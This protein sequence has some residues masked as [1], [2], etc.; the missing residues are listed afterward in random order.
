M[1]MNF[2]GSTDVRRV[3]LGNRSLVGRNRLVFLR[4]AQIDRERREAL[5][6]QEDSANTIQRACQRYL[7]L[8]SWRYELSE[9][10]DGLSIL[11]FKYFFPYLVTKQSREL[12]ISQLKEIDRLF[13]SLNI[14]DCSL[15]LD[16]F[17]RSVINLAEKYNSTSD[18][19]LKSILPIMVRI[20]QT[21]DTIP[22]KHSLQFTTSL[23]ELY[24]QN[25][26]NALYYLCQLM[27][28]VSLKHLAL[29]IIKYTMIFDISISKKWTDGYARFEAKFL[30]K[31][32][33]QPDVLISL[34]DDRKILLVIRIS[35]LTRQ[36]PYFHPL[37]KMHFSIV[38]IL[39][40]SIKCKIH[41]V[42]EKDM[43]S[44]GSISVYYNNEI[45]TLTKQ[46]LNLFEF[47]SNRIFFQGV[48]NKEPDVDF[49]IGYISSLLQFATL[50]EGQPG[51]SLKLN[52][53][54]DW[55]IKDHFGD[56]IPT[57]IQKISE[58]TDIIYLESIP[59][60]TTERFLDVELH[61]AW[62]RPMSILQEFLLDILSIA[63]DENLFAA[64]KM[65]KNQVIHFGTFLKLMITEVLMKYRELR[66][67]KSAIDAQGLFLAYFERMLSLTH[68]LYMKDLRLKIFMDGFWVLHNFEF[69]SEAI[70]N[71]IP[72]INKL[73][74]QEIPEKEDK[75]VYNFLQ[76]SKL[77]SLTSSNVPK[78]IIDSLY[79][80]TYAPYVIPFEKRA[81]IFHG[82]IYHDK[83]DRLLL[84]W[85]PRKVEATVSR[86]NILFD[87][88]IEFGSVPG[89]EFKRPFSISF[90]NKFGE[91]EAGIDGGG[92][93][94]EFLT[95]LVS[96]SFIPSRENRISN[97]GLQFFREGANHKLYFN[98]EYYFKLEYEKLH[99][100]QIIPFDCE[101]G[102]YHDFCTLLG[103]VIGKCLYDN[104]L[105]DISFTPFF[106]NACATMGGRY[107]SN[108]IGD[109][110]EFIG[111]SFSFDELKNLDSSL[112]H[113]LNYILKQTTE[114]R[115]KEMAIDCVVD[116]DVYDVYGRKHH[117]TLPLLPPGPDGKPVPVTLE[118]RYKFVRLMTSFKLSKQTNLMMKPFVE[119]LFQV[120]S[121]HWFVLFDPYE[122][123][124]LI[125]GEDLVDLEDLKNNA[126]LGGGYTL[127][128]PTIIDLFEILEEFNHKERGEFVKF[129]TSSSK[130]PLLGFKELEPKFGIFRAGPTGNRLPTASTCINLLKLPDY[131]NKEI[132]RDKLLYSIKSGAGF[133]LS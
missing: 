64:I 116:D 67:R 86:D 128:S 112:Y 68:G 59:T 75:L 99:P 98:P 102:D 39:L 29:F 16:A 120:I 48:Y 127:Q 57:C 113:S 125:S 20:C 87:S 124:T 14:H 126:V 54:R 8:Q 130:Q 58:F 91:I 115:F 38:Q 78:K 23:I 94:K 106:L 1:S 3:N 101:D 11:H 63:A 95:S 80:L 90:V 32:L 55:L 71:I 104:I 21:Y 33:A 84:E 49:L 25:F 85:N 30:E 37:G 96:S 7:K 83:K 121:P 118:N 24:E 9:S 76:N 110:V 119:G 100:N 31:L 103:R 61:R 65:T 18:E 133:D 44:R 77:T 50:I 74:N 34:P 122:L 56:L 131:C 123:Q 10:W 36:Y 45:L 72:L 13:D 6:L 97:H 47:L 22:S 93:T 69:D 27:N 52:I 62:W 70:I 108:L 41:L 12:S 107:F 117:V 51:V 73:H 82:F 4:S 35:I 42:E 40:H 26:E 111:Y 89:Y 2:T 19:L 105:L 43:N 81:E 46:A 66:K 5:R 79:V 28:V 60:S 129:V 15:L 109:K 92:I 17:V 132:L 53:T 114:S 88:L